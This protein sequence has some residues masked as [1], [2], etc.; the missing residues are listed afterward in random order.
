MYEFVRGPLLWISFIVFIGGSLFKLIYMANLAKKKDIYVYEYMSL[1]YGLRSILHWI[2]PFGSVNMR[3]RP[4]FTI[5]SFAFHICLIFTP[6][7]LLAHN[8]LWYESWKISWWTISESIADWMTLVVIAAC[9]FFAVRRIVRPEVKYV[10]SASDF[11]LLTMAAAP[12][13]TGFLAYH[14]W[15]AYKTM[16]IIHILCGEIMLMAIPFTRLSHMLFF[17]LTRAYMGSEFG[18]VRHVKDY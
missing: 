10:T 16:L 8:I 1:K 18:A 2:I 3:Q 5:V 13:I 9:V 14:Q 6:I 11:L 7:F 15:F 12:F 4:V 17:P